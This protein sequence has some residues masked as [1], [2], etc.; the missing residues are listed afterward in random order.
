MNLSEY[1]GDTFPDETVPP[2]IEMLDLPKNDYIQ[3]GRTR[4]PANRDLPNYLS[5]SL[6]SQLNTESQTSK[7]KN[8][9]DAQLNWRRANILRSSTIS[10]PRDKLW[11]ESDNRRQIKVKYAD[12]T[13]PLHM[14]RMDRRPATGK[15]SFSEN[16]LWDKI[17][18]QYY[19]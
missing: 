13:L 5:G 6:D 7:N 11:D 17:E 9:Q 18:Q 10:S 15:Q 2:Y 1:S 4:A 8:A 19:M 3:L 12:W 16:D 14:G